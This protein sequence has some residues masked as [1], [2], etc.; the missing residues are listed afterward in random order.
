MFLKTNCKKHFYGTGY[1]QEFV[2]LPQR[3]TQVAPAWKTVCGFSYQWEFVKVDRL[4]EAVAI[5]KR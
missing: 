5:P 1:T 3:G 2:S 4:R